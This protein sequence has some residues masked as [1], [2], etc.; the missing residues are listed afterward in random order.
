MADKLKIDIIEGHSEINIMFDV[1][2][3]STEKAYKSNPI[4]EPTQYYESKK[5]KFM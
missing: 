5:P 2:G 3:L 4:L 1:F